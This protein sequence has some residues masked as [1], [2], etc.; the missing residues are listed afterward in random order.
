MSL[1]HSW[2]QWRQFLLKCVDLAPGTQQARKTKYSYPCAKPSVPTSFRPQPPQRDA[3]GSRQNTIC[4][5]LW[6][7]SS[8]RK[9]GQGPGTVHHEER[10]L[11]VTVLESPK[12]QTNKRRLHNYAMRKQSSRAS[13]GLKTGHNCIQ[14]SLSPVRV[15]IFILQE[16][17]GF[18][19]G[20]NANCETNKLPPGSPCS[21]H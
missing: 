11:V 6:E 2:C 12:T 13:Q 14:V 20:Q 16:H 15:E 9:Q 1:G 8:G 17:Y 18:Q 7:L 10:L 21:L 5:T 4:Q 3:T 19:W